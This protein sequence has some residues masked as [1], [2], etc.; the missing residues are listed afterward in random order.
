MWEKLEEI[1]RRYRELEAEMAR[2]EVAAD[3]DR[4][5]PAN[6]EYFTLSRLG[7]VIFVSVLTGP[8]GLSGEWAMRLTTW[9]GFLV[10]VLQE[11]KRE[12]HGIG[13]VLRRVWIELTTWKT[14]P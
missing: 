1:E 3:Y 4:L 6:L 12:L 13:E 10:L 9:L 11:F 7:T 5:H 14:K 2:P 8:L